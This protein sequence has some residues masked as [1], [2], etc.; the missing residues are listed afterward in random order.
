MDDLAKQLWFGNLQRF[1]WVPAPLAG[2]QVSNVGFVEQIAYQNGGA[3]IDRSPAY[4]KEYEFAFNAPLKGSENLNVFNKYASGFYGTGLLYFADPY[5]FETN[6]FSAH[7][8][9]PGLIEQGWP[10]ISE[11]APT[12]GNTASNSYL[13]P[14]RS[15]TFTITSGVGAPFDDAHRFVIPIPPTHTLHIGASGTS[16]GAGVVQVRPVNPDGSYAATSNLTLLNPTAATRMNATFAGSSYSAVE[17]Y[18]ARTSASAA[19]VTLVSMMA[20]LW[21]AGITPTLTGDHIPGDGHTGLAFADEARAE[22]YQYIN[23]PRRALSTVLTEVG[24]WR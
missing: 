8:A 2:A 13:Q 14:P 6:L 24:A 16:T 3:D 17:V 22:T 9:S 1:Q 11:F 10:S 5:A 18:I 19:T 15:A 7:W 4:R 12:F 21:K 23:P 20:Q